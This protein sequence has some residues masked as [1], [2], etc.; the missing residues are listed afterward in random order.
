MRVK[1]ILSVIFLTSSLALSQVGGI[2]GGKLSI[3]DAGI[4]EQGTLEFEPSFSVSHSNYFFGTNGNSHS[5]YGQK[6][7]SSFLFRITV[8]ITENLEIGS[9][10]PSTMEQIDF[11]AKQNVLS[12]DNLGLAI[13]GGV[14]L[15]AGNKFISDSLSNNAGNY[16]ASFGGTLS[17]KFNEF[18][19]KRL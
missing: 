18:T 14:S 6:V 13:T 15:P 8:G 2:S 12:T 1:I 16:M 5:L 19:L 4:I 3:P 7:N 11:G 10:I 9:S 17:N